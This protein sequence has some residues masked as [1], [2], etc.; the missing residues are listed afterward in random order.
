[1]GGGGG[2]T[3]LLDGEEQLRRRPLGDLKAPLEALGAA[4]RFVEEEGHAPV[5]VR[6]QRWRGGEVAVPGETS[7]QFL[8][9]IL[10]G[11]PLAEGP[12]VVRARELVSAPYAALTAHL[13]AR[14]GVPVE[15][16]GNAFGVRPGTYRAVS[17]E[18]EPD[19]S[20][21]AF[22]FAAAAVSGG[23]VTVPGVHPGLLQGDASFPRFLAA[24]G[25]SVEAGPGGTTVRGLPRRGLEADVAGVPDLVP[26]LV[27]VALRAPEPSFLRGVAHLRHK[28]SDR[29][30]V[31]SEGVAALGGRLEATG[32]VLR[33]HPLRPRGGAS[34]NPRGDHR[35]AM[36]FAVTG[37]WVPGLL[38]EDPAC[39]AKSFPR[40][41]DVLL[42]LLV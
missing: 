34:L 15:R 16:R 12:L 21:A 28:E 3:F 22:L 35:M 26:P 11:A 14:F 13:M 23:E 4:V 20:A 38:V 36:A 6:G 37:L 31:L 27:A 8:S 10:L 41:F 19:A 42:S 29:L 2:G 18:V 30:E 5:E 7:S 33:V 40:F 17:L 39:V 25:V 9:G 24:M 1:R 32:D